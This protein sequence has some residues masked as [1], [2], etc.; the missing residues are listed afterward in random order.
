MSWCLVQCATW[1]TGPLLQVLKL[2][3]SCRGSHML[4]V[5]SGAQPLMVAEK[6]VA[7]LVG[8]ISSSATA[9]WSV[10]VPRDLRDFTLSFPRSRPGPELLVCLPVV[11]IL[12]KLQTLQGSG[13]SY[14][15]SIPININLSILQTAWLSETGMTLM[16]NTWHGVLWALGTV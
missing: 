11:P 6:G 7:L 16:Q 1:L 10:C 14:V 12:F 2:Q 3:R 9:L 5:Q 8:A 13:F 4:M 15:H